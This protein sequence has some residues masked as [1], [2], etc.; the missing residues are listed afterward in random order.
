MEQG[1]LEFVR[2][3]ALAGFRLDTPGGFQL[4]NLS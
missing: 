4:G 1:M 3:D 2:D